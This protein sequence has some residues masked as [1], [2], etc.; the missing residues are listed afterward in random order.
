MEFVVF[1]PF[2]MYFFVLKNPFMHP[3][4]APATDAAPAINT[5]PPSGTVIEDERHHLP[6]STPVVEVQ[7]QPVPASAPEDNQAAPSPSFLDTPQ[8]SS[9]DNTPPTTPTAP[10][11]SDVVTTISRSKDPTTI[12]TPPV[13]FAFDGS[14]NF[15]T[16]SAI[17]YWE[18]IP[19]G[20]AWV[21]MVKV[22]LRLEQLPIQPG[23]RN[24]F[25]VS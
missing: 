25:P 4:T 23:V 17:G 16:P 22:Y 15:I 20:Q 24:L 5:T 18:T 1:I 10:T 21:D 6:P 13:V 3:V 9:L 11:T 19:G 2:S 14:S 8:Q 12:P 7:P